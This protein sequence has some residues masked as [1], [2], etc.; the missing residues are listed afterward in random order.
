MNGIPI[1]VEGAHLKC[2]EKRKGKKRSKLR[3]GGLLNRFLREHDIEEEEADYRPAYDPRGIEV[4]KTKEPEGINGP[5]LF[6]NEHNA[7]IDNMLSHLYNYPL[8]EHS[9]ALC[10]VGPGYEEPL[11]DDVSMEDEMTRVDSDLESSD[12]NEEDSEMGEAA[13]A[14]T[15]NKE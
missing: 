5:V 10:R 15:E 13:L 14:P 6:F 12:D 2:V 9:R 3:I 11:D 7:R 1:N 4:T 8:S